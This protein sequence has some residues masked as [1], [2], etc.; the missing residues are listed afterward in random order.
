MTAGLVM[1]RFERLEAW[2]A[3]HRLTIAVYH[4]VKLLPEYERY[5]LSQQMRRAAV[6]VCANIAE[7]SAK[8]GRAEFRRFLDMANGSMTELRCLLLLARDLQML[9]EDTWKAV[10]D[11]R[12]PAGYLLWRL[13]RSLSP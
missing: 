2:K 3:C 10:E 12:R 6:S 1:A 5:G 9:P 4:S 8:R 13:Y 7:G 11:V